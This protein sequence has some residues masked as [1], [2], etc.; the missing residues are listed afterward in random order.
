METLRTLYE[1][2][3]KAEYVC[4]QIRDLKIYRSFTF[5]V[6]ISFGKWGERK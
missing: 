6:W 5:Q 4:L 1:V 2:K 3:G